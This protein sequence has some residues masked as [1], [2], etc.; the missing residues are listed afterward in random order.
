MDSL[1]GKVVL[2]K[3]RLLFDLGFLVNLIL[4]ARILPR[5]VPVGFLTDSV[6]SE[7]DLVDSFCGWI[8]DPYCF[9]S[10]RNV[11]ALLIDVGDEL[12]SLL[13][14]YWFVFFAHWSTYFSR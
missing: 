4:E 6:L 13:I 1:T 12:E 7:I 8:I 11:H 9:G 5:S 2:L 14:G 3:T 10:S